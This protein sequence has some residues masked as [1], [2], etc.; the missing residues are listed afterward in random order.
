MMAT[1]ILIENGNARTLKKLKFGGDYDESWLQSRLFENPDSLPLHE[2]NPAFQNLTPICTELSTS[3]GPIDIVYITPQGK[4]VVVETKLFKNPEARRKVIGQLLDYAKELVTWSYAD[5]QRQ[6]SIRTGVKG[7]SVFKLVSGKYPEVDEA[8][9]HDGVTQSL[10]KGDFMLIIAGDGI[11]QDAQAIIEFLDST[12]QMRFTL[13]LIEAAVFQTEDQELTFIQPRVL[14][15]TKEVVR[16]FLLTSLAAE[17]STEPTASGS[18]S[19]HFSTTDLGQWYLSFWTDFFHSLQLD[20][21]EQVIPV[22]LA[23]GSRTFGLP[24][25]GAVCWVNAYFYKATKEIGCFVRFIAKEQG[26]DLF[27]RLLEDK[28]AISN[29]L[30]FEVEWDVQDQK[31]KID[32]RFPHS[33][34]PLDAH[35]DEVKEFFE[36]T[37]NGFVN[38]FRPRLLSLMKE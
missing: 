16:Q 19:E 17:V 30:P 29:E 8:E 1:P 23:N 3:A 27:R 2:I 25:T 37:I 9:L 33:E 31:I 24:P 14:V 7:N 6:V 22:P 10:E 15:K 4:L 5:L 35:A 34:W 18:N 38:A 21:P 32:K 20:D 36:L 13:G 11:R 28:D 26:Q 12:A